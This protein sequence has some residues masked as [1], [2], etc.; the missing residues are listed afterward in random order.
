M[1]NTAHIT[2][3]LDDVVAAG[4]VE[5]AIAKW[6][7]RSDDTSCGVVGSTFATSG[8]GSGW[9]RNFDASDYASRALRE[10]AMYYV[11][12]SDGRM[13]SSES[14]EADDDDDDEILTDIGGGHYREGEW[15]NKSVVCVECPDIDDAIEHPDMVAKMAKA[16]IDSHHAESDCS[17]WRKLI[18]SIRS[19]AEAVEDIDIDSFPAE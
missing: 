14:A 5:A 19:S 6:C 9:T 16:I 1:A 15:T 11:D 8:P 17:A 2:I 4:S 7:E 3:D 13:L 12:E 18:E 10:G